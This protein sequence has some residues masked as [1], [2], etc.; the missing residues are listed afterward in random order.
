MKVSFLVTVHN[1][2]DDLNILLSQLVKYKTES[3]NDSEIVVLDDFSDNPKTI[4][5]LNNFKN[6]IVWE[7]H[8]LNKKFGP[9][10]QYGNT[11]C[12]GDYIFQVD[13]DE[14][15]N[16]DLLEN[17]VPLLESNS[18]IDLMMI[19][20]VNRIKGLKDEH[21]MK[22]GWRANKFPTLTETRND[23]SSGE[24]D[25]LKRN[26]LIISEDG[27]NVTF[28]SVV[29][30]W[31][32]YQFRLYRNS[33][34]IKWERDLHELIVGADKVTYLPH[35]DYTWALFHDKTIEKQEQQNMFYNQ[36]FSQELNVRR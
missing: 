14:R 35:E 30:N 1:E 15:F 34:D 36:N 19:P 22:W 32:D 8:Y 12:S 21:I 10:K 23:L 31:P 3:N 9:H 33:S 2:T 25:F 28:Y 7:K 17:M 26:N 11:K 5:I 13:A 16:E 18:G 27:S 4:E 6:D 29:I 20:R 24:L